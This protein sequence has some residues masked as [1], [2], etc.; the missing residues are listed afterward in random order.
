MPKI[1]QEE[2]EVLKRLDDKWEWITRDRY[3]GEKEYENVLGGIRVFSKKPFKSPRD[4]HFG[5]D[6][7]GMGIDW[8]YLD[9]DMFFFI[10]PYLF[11]TFLTAQAISRILLSV[12]EF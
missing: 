12:V 10:K 7:K 8:L 9:R 2:Y 3:R 1:N 5:V 4:D 11:P 6:G